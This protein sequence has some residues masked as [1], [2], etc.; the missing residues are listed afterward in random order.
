MKIQL[1]SLHLNDVFMKHVLYNNE[2]FYVVDVMLRLGLVMLEKENDYREK[3]IVSMSE[4]VELIKD[5]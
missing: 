5:F 3:I 4:E 1:G 2:R